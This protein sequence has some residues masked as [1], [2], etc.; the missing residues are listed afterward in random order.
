MRKNKHLSIEERSIIKSMLDQS[1]SFKAIARQLGRDCTTISKEVRNHLVF[2]KT[3]CFGHPF[4]DCAN[5]FSCPISGLC[6]D[7][8]CHFKKCSF[9]SKCHLYC[10]DY[11]KQYCP[12]LSKPPYVCNGCPLRHKCTLE[13]HLYSASAAQQEYELVRSPDLASVWMRPRLFSWTA[14]FL[15]YSE[16]DSPYTT[17]VPPILPKLCS[18]KRLFTITLMPASS[19]PE[20]STCQERFPISPE[21]LLMTLL[22][23][24]NPAGL[25]VLIRIFRLS[26][27]A[28]L[29]V[30]WSRWIP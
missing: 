6:S 29:I 23:S 27:P 24:I 2:K 18:R 17:F 12:S 5:R 4:N 10:S 19:L 15:L 21:N 30:R 3:G 20:I 13:K 8:A 14:S 26:S 16:K 1:A 25:V 22:R 9:C 7:S 28:G 11:F